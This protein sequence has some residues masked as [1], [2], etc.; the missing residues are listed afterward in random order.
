MLPAPAELW[1]TGAID[2]AE[3]QR[4]HN[5]CWAF[6]SVLLIPQGLFHKRLGSAPG[7]QAPSKAA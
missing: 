4:P 5:L 2:I 3:R 1:S 6:G 7:G